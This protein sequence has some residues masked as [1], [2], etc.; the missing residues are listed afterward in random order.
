MEP[1]QIIDWLIKGITAL[2]TFMYLKTDKDLK[3]TRAKLFD[4]N[5]KTKLELKDLK[6]KM[7]LT[8][9]RHASD[10]IQFQSLFNLKIDQLAENMNTKIDE[11]N[12]AI[13]HAEKN[14]IQSYNAIAELLKNYQKN[15]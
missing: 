6:S 11:I 10:L 1:G 8:D 4:Y 7:E 15:K 12:R 5:N 9:Q 2:I 3:D 13:L 14:S